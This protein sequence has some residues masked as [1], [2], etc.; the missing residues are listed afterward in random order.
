MAWTIALILLGNWVVGLMSGAQLGLFLHAFLLGALLS[1]LLGAL[2][3]ARQARLSPPPGRST[4]RP[5]P[6]P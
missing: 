1:L 2:G 6:A 3:C 4:G 5:G